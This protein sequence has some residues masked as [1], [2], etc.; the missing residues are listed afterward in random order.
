MDAITMLKA[1]HKTVE[2]MF[3]KFEGLGPRAMKGRR[4]VV[5]RI[6]RELSIHAV[7]E[8]VIFYPAIREM[9][10][11][12]DVND[13]VLEAL[14]EHH[15]LKWTL[16][17]LEG[18]DP[19]HER[20]DA[21]V[22]VLMESVRHHVKEEEKA[23]FPQVRRMFDRARLLELGDAMTQL[24]KTA[25]TRPHPKAPDEPPGNLVAGAAAAIADRT[26]EAGRRLLRSA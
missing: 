14:E 2:E 13:M 4:D 21:K 5:D 25:P 19:A 15:V 7:I 24:K 18:M 10:E 11:K 6:I 8:E 20:F 23:L 3:K 26:L 16:K 17:E 1:D 9:A 12:N 22:N